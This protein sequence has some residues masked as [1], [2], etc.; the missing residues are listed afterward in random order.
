MP[1]DWIPQLVASKFEDWFGLPGVVWLYGAS[2]LV[3]MV[4][5]YL[6]CRREA[7]PLPAALATVMAT[8]AAA[9]SLSQRPQ[10]ISFILMLVVVGAWLET[11]RDGR[12]RWWLVPLTWVWAGSHGMWYCGIAV[13][14]AVVAGMALDGRVTRGEVAKLAAIPA[15][16][17]V[18]AAVTPVGPRLLV[19]VFDTTGMWEF[20]TEWAAPSFREFSPA[21]ALMMILVIVVTW[22]RRTSRTPWAHI[23]LVVIAVGWTLL[24]A[25]TVALGAVVLAPLLAAVLHGWIRRGLTQRAGK[26]EV[27]Y[28]G[29]LVGACLIGLALVVPN[30]AATP[31]KVPNG[32]DDELAALPAGSSIL[33]EYELGGW[34]HWRHPELQT[35]V[36]G[37]TDG[38][39]P[40]AIAEYVKAHDVAAGWEDYVATTGAKSALLQVD[41]PLATALVDRLRWEPVATDDEFVLLRAP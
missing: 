29:L 19:T 11:I 39:T 37:F 18:A 17:F 38:Y 24:S 41:S 12:A 23:G 28:L 13:G 33:N 8:M 3:F 15:L 40:S 35:V 31:G 7:D 5:A 20:V 32:L 1:R 26:F 22:A 2:L 36:D 25:R 6:T 4:A 30:T 14:I 9:G 21:T 34:L 16:S 27:G 10:M